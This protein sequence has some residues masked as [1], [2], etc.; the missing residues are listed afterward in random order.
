[1]TPHPYSIEDRR[2]PAEPTPA[3]EAFD[4]ACQDFTLEAFAALFDEDEA[5]REAVMEA[6]HDC[7]IA[8][9]NNQ[10]NARAA[11]VGLWRVCED[12]IRRDVESGIERDRMADAAEAYAEQSA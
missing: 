3:E 9:D 2:Q 1:M 11:C 4:I 8:G 12:A 5:F 6:A 10:A 7:A